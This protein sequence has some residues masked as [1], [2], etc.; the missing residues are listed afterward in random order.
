MAHKAKMPNEDSRYSGD[1]MKGG[2][3]GSGG[4]MKGSGGNTGAST[5]LK[6]SDEMRAD[7]TKQPT[8]KNPYP[9]GLA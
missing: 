9:K 2:G 3:Y 7:V 8:N 4:G 6:K 1:S 5:G